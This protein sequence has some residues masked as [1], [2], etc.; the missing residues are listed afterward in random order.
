MMNVPRAQLAGLLVLITAFG[1]S[2]AK[3]AVDCKPQPQELTPERLE[4]V[5]RA[6]GDARLGDARSLLIQRAGPPDVDIV[7]V[8]KSMPSVP[9]ERYIRY[10]FYRVHPTLENMHDELVTLYFDL[11]TDQLTEIISNVKG[12]PSLRK[13]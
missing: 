13:N 5:R 11:K 4:R 12:I 7:D 9:T 2:S 1:C 8:T 3:H 6:I 10:Y